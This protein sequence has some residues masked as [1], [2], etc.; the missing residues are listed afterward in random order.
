MG[1]LPSI[2]LALW[3]A[4]SR[5]AQHGKWRSGRGVVPCLGRKLLNHGRLFAVLGSTGGKPAQH[6]RETGARLEACPARVAKWGSVLRLACK[7]VS[8]DLPVIGI[9]FP[10]DPSESCEEGP[11]W[12]QTGGARGTR[13]AGRG[14][15]AG[16]G[17]A[18]LD[19]WRP[20]EIRGDPW[21]SVEMS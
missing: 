8:A 3:E 4:V 7:A 1:G 6:G 5:P 15:R 16:C 9:A 11:P 17:G 18:G 14:R 20:V 13:G 19:P 12:R 21:R 10:P 2:I